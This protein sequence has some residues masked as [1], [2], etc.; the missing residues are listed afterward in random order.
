MQIAPYINKIDLTVHRNDTLLKSF[1]V[2]D[3]AGNDIDLTTHQNAWLHVRKYE[4]DQATVL[5]LSSASHEITLGVG[6]FDLSTPAADMDIEPG[7]YVYDIEFE[8]ASGNR[9]TH[10]HGTFTV[11]PDVTRP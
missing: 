8:D 10:Q 6:Q 1:T 11:L 9:H 4:S 2:K 7:K 3:V 5:T